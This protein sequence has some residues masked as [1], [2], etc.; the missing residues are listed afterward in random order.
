MFFNLPPQIIIFLLSMLPVGEKV[1]IPV[2]IKVYGLSPWESFVITVIGSF[3]PTIA[4]VYLMGPI[5]EFFS[6]RFI[7]VKKLFDWLFYHTRK[8]HTKYFDIF[9]ELSLLVFVSIPSPITGPW[10]GAL[11][12]FVFGIPPKKALPFIFGGCFISGIIITFLTQGAT[13][14]FK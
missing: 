2:A 1:A 10:G 14:L 11:A 9:K 3:I 4:I 8:R 12:S 7:K 6:K 13:I 5:S